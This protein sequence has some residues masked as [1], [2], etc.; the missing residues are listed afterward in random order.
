MTKIRP[1]YAL[2]A[3]GVFMAL[4]LAADQYARGRRSYS[5]YQRVGLAADGVVRIDV[6]DLERLEVRFYR[7]LN[8]ANQEVRFLVG[9]DREGIVQVGFDANDSHYKTGR[10]FSYQDGWITDNKCDTTTRLSAINQGGRGCKPAA[11]KH[12]VEGDQLIVT[13]VDMLAGWRYF[14]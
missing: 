8:T 7:F 14:R 5:A 10:G 12:R 9:R 2:I 11:V 3:I 13:E 4:V 1:A 6:G